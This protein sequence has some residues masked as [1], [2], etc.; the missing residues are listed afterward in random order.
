MGKPAPLRFLP[1]FS[2]SRYVSNAWLRHWSDFARGASILCESHLFALAS[3]V[4]SCGGPESVG[5]PRHPAWL[6]FSHR[7]PIVPTAKNMSLAT[8]IREF[9]QVT[10][11]QIVQDVKNLPSSPKV[12]PR[13]KRLLQDGNS[14]M[15]EIALLIRLDA[16]IAAR[17]MRVSNSAFYNQGLRCETVEESVNRV[18]FNHIYQLVSYAVASQVLVRP[19]EVYGLEVDQVWRQSVACA[20][21]AQSIALISGDDGDLAYTF[22]LLHRIGMV[23]VNEWALRKRPQLRLTADDFPAEFVRSERAIFGGT[24]ADVGAELLR[25]WEFPPDTT[26]PVQYQYSPREAASET[27]MAS[28][29][30]AARWV[31]S[32]VCGEPGHPVLPDEAALASLRLSHAQLT[33]V[34]KDV[35]AHLQTISAL[36]VETEEMP[37]RARYGHDS[38]ADAIHHPESFSRPPI[39]VPEKT[40]G[41]LAGGSF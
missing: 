1:D 34:A 22:G 27:R 13:L 37:M 21:A 25:H 16:A 11:Q 19:L 31:R 24:Q 14:S 15:Q 29:L 10:P 41:N 6:R 26:R 36:L 35:G 17:V 38:R 28:L 23:A 20:L 4:G 32:V 5:K 3:L 8:P 30:Y 7:P 40:L 9:G 2:D 12:L 33:G 39:S 18:G